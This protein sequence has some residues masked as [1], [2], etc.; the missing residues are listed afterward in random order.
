MSGKQSLFGIG[1]TAQS[2]GQVG[3]GVD[4]QSNAT[5]IDE[6]MNGGQA[7]YSNKRPVIIDEI[8]GI[9]AEYANGV[10]TPVRGTTAMVIKNGT[11]YNIFMEGAVK[12]DLDLYKTLLTTFKITN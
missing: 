9:M 12:A 3:G 6:F 10:G 5:S 7:T 1:V 2:G 4:V 11:L 8:S